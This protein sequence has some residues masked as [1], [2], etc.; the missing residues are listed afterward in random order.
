MWVYKRIAFGLTK[1]PSHGYRHLL[2]RFAQHANAAT[3]W[4]IYE[5]DNTLDPVVMAERIVDMMH[6]AQS[7]HF[8]P[9]GM[10][11]DDIVLTDIYQNG[12]LGAGEG[13]WT[14]W[15]FFIIVSNEALLG[16]T[17]FYLDG[18][19]MQDELSVG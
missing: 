15:E 16:K 10:L 3:Y 6:N 2:G 12:A 17:T 1:H 18:I 8:N 4:D 5:D 7:I 11:T 13:N 9:D 19:I 14:N